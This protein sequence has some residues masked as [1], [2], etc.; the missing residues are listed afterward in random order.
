MPGIAAL[1]I[2]SGGSGA[3]SGAAAQPIVQSTSSN[4]TARTSRNTALASE[5]LA[6]HRHDRRH[7]AEVAEAVANL[8]RCARHDALRVARMRYGRERI[9]RSVQ[10]YH[11]AVDSPHVERVP[12][13]A[14]GDAIV[15][16]AD[17]TLRDHLR[18]H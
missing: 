13:V 18:H 14:V 4:N 1:R 5:Q 11:G 8:E 6:E 3:R 9:A 12:T 17:G 7:D 16:K 15:G 10:D 2:S